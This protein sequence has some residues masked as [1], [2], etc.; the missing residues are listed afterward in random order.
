MSLSKSQNSSLCTGVRCTVC[1]AVLGA[2]NGNGDTIT[3]VAAQ[4][5]VSRGWLGG[6]G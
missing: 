2:R 4:F 3:D 5:G 6:T 1:G